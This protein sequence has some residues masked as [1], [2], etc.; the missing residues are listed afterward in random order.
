[1]EIGISVYKVI[2]SGPHTW[3]TLSL[4]ALQGEVNSA[5]QGPMA[6]LA[7]HALRNE[8]FRDIVMSPNTSSPEAKPFRF[9]QPVRFHGWS[10]ETQANRHFVKRNIIPSF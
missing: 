6:S 4:H 7:I 5:E 10:P 8:R 9:S 1:M 2:A 3:S